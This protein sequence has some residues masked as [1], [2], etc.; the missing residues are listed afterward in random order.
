MRERLAAESGLDLA[1]VCFTAAASRSQMPVRLAVVART[2]EQMAEQLRPLAEGGGSPG[3][4]RPTGK[5][6]PL[7]FL[8]TG[9]GSQYFGMSAQ[10]YRT[11]PQFRRALDRCDELFRPHLERPLLDVIFAKHGDSG[12]LNET[13][14][15]QPAL[16]A[17]EVALAALWRSWGVEARY[18]GGAGAEEGDKGTSGSPQNRS[19]R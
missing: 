11:L 10:L 2:R 8:F 4:A 1:D 6:K 16:F 9:Q 17:L 5:R 7:A 15:T 19:L 13:A 14:Y 3:L 18:W 12:L